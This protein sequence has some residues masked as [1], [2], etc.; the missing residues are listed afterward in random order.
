MAAEREEKKNRETVSSERNRV[1]SCTDALRNDGNP[2]WG[3]SARFFILSA[4]SLA[5]PPPISL[6]RSGSLRSRARDCFA[7]VP[8]AR[9]LFPLFARASVRPRRLYADSPVSLAAPASLLQSSAR[10]RS[11]PTSHATACDPPPRVASI[12]SHPVSRPCL[13]LTDAG[14]LRRGVLLLRVHALCLVELFCWQAAPPRSS[15]SLP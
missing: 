11:T 5:P 8:S 12:P 1:V 2:R 4:G 9:A 14:R 13:G 6:A 3:D 15:A 7:L 10:C